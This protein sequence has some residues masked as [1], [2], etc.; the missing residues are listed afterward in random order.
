MAQLFHDISFSNDGGDDSTFPQ[1]S[2]PGANRLSLSNADLRLDA[3]RKLIFPGDAPLSV[4]GDFTVLTGSPTPKERLR[5]AADGTVSVSGEL[6]VAGAINGTDVAALRSQVEALQ[7]PARR[8]TKVSLMPAFLPL[9]PSFSSQAHTL[10]PAWVCGMAGHDSEL[11]SFRA[12]KAAAKEAAGVIPLTLPDGATVT[13]LEV[14]GFLVFQVLEVALFRTSMETE[15]RD[16]TVLIR[17]TVP[18]AENPYQQSFPAQTA[19]RIN[20]IDNGR[21]AYFVFARSG[22]GGVVQIHRI[23]IDYTW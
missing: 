9:T 20:E 11:F 6:K 21:F 7:R 14:S 3:G 2:S 4:S 10:A 19:N 15:S 16:T 13:A 5:I 18:I 12:E 22:L 23:R 17:G 8:A 1:L